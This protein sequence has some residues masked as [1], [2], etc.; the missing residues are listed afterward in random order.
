MK[1]GVIL[2]HANA[3][4]I[5]KREWIQK[6]IQSIND[7]TF[8]DFNIY[9]I[10]Y[11]NK[12]IN[13]YSIYPGSYFWQIPMKNYSY[14]QNFITDRAFED[15]CSHVFVVNIDDYYHPERFEKQL[16][17]KDHDIVSSNFVYIQD[18][19]E[20][21]KM[22]FSGAN[23]ESNFKMNRNVIAHPAVCMNRKFWATN[24]Y[25]PD[26]IPQEDFDLWKRAMKAGFSFKIVPEILLFYRI[27]S[28]QVGNS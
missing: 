18:D 26:M 8:E 16:Q 11:S 24:K 1:I 2:F 5:Y 3:E 25:N 20:T 7:Q 6:C 9:E 28:N 19:K 15:G 13:K 10:D 17:F 27:H 21:K 12:P 23:I 22:I 14:A 4:K